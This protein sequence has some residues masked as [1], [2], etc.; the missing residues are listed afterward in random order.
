MKQTFICSYLKHHIYLIEQNDYI[1]YIALPYKDFTNTNITIDLRSDYNNFKLANGLDIA[2]NN[3]NSLYQNIDNYNITLVLPMT[4]DNL[5]EEIIAN[6]SNDNFLKMDKILGNIINTAYDF[7]T[8]NNITVESDIYILNENNYSNFI[9]WFVNRYQTRVHVK[10]LDELSHNPN[11]E[12]TY[13]ILDTPNMSFVVG[14]NDDTTVDE[15]K[16]NI[17][18]AIEDIIERNQEPK[19]TNA[20]TSPGYASYWFLGIITIVLSFIILSLLVK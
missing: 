1:F 15:D 10:S 3:L 8:T 11:L 17:P 4:S 16:K 7:L 18:D 14:K 9:N 20:E 5:L 6:P 2:I 13:N 12:N 19:I